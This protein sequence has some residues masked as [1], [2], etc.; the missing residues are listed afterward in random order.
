MLYL[1]EGDAEKMLFKNRQQAGLRLASRFNFHSLTRPIVIALP[2]GGVPV[3]Y[4]IA[5]T[6]KAPLT[7]LAV[8]KIGD[9]ANPEYGL[10]AVTENGVY[11]I[12][13]HALRL[14]GAKESDVK[15]TLLKEYAELERRVSRY[16]NNE[17]LPRL[18]GRSVIV[19]DDGIAMGVTAKVA[20]HYLKEHKAKEIILAAPVCSPDS[21][22]MLRP[23]VD[24]FICLSEPQHF[25]S[26]GRFYED[27]TQTTDR[28]VVELLQK[29]KSWIR[30]PQPVSMT[31]TTLS[32]SAEA[33]LKIAQPLKKPE[34]LGPLIDQIAKSK[35]VMLG[36]ASHGTHEFY[37]WRRIISEWLITKHGFKFIA[38]EGDW[39]ACEDLNQY[40]LGNSNDTA[41]RAL[42]S[43]TRWPTWMWANTD[44]ARL[45]SWMKTHNHIAK[46]H[47]RAGFHGLDVYSLFESIAVVLK[48]AEKIN[49]F[50][51]KRLRLRYAC[52]DPYQH[53]ERAYA[54]S[55]LEFPEGCEQEVNETL[56]ELLKM[57]LENAGNLSEALFDAEQNARVVANAEKY[58]RAM[59]HA[60]DNSW[61]I[62]DRH[63]LETLDVLL[64]HY[65]EESKCI[66]WAHN[67]HIGDYR[68]TDM[69]RQGNI[70]IGGL[71]REKWGADAVSL[72]GFGSYQ[73]KVT[74][75]HAWDGPIETITV[76]PGRPG[77]T[78][79]AFH[80]AALKLEEDAFFVSLQDPHTKLGPLS[81]IQGHRAIGVVYQ[82][83][84]E[85]FGNYVP[86]SLTRRYDA[87]VYIDQTTALEPLIQHFDRRE[88]PEAWPSGQ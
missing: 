8:R 9:P 62:R 47:Q 51:A 52:F 74:A 39:P 14:S 29:S 80:E 69:V 35:I 42:K 55:L 18:E 87:F 81:T 30:K 21:A 37:Q 63:M 76:P 27:F 24:R 79:A 72:V 50:L 34:D 12:D 13:T 32:P 53:D 44:V 68:A 77:S 54:K 7:V 28:Q 66:V 22:A 6:L 78:E 5:K 10:G 56:Q 57:R 1:R 49:P 70:N 86:T 2:R 40:V 75:S 59:L 83:E 36:E 46:P 88:I 15:N 23:E 64:K 31:D 17:P 82:P 41:L 84:H 65:G 33:I 60:D 71:A 73:G 4:E 48:Q 58:Y 25:S 67:T 38:V 3:A 85:H 20:C 16:R 45:A 11:W 61:N 26:V 19:V 43:F